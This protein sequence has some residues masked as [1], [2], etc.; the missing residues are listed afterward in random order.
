[1]KPSHRPPAVPL[2]R[3]AAPAAGVRAHR[4]D[5]DGALQGS[6]Q[7]EYFYDMDRARKPTRPHAALDDASHKQP[8]YDTAASENDLTTRAAHRY[9]KR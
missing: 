8:L 6:Q 7:F 4:P 3:P 5:L 1:M 9:W 2:S